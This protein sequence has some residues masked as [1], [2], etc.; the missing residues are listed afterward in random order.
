ME[1]Q[2][3]LQSAGDVSEEGGTLRTVRTAV[4]WLIPLA[5]GVGI[6]MWLFQQVRFEQQADGV[7]SPTVAVDLGLIRP[8]Q[9]GHVGQ[10]W[11]VRAQDGWFQYRA[12]YRGLKSKEGVIRASTH[13]DLGKLCAKMSPTDCRLLHPRS[14]QFE[15]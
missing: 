1:K 10:V 13:V 2:A 14:P 7:M 6:A 3:L 4:S 8:E 15:Q 11:F 12:V 9:V 5:I